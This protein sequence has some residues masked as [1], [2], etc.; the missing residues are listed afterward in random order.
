MLFLVSFP[1]GRNHL[2]KWTCIKKAML[3]SVFM[4]V[5]IHVSQNMNCISFGAVLSCSED[6]YSGLSVMIFFS[7]RRLI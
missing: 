1:E 5:Y 2:Y 4:L 7:I 6:G 3:C